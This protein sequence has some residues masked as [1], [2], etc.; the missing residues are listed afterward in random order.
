MDN[1]KGKLSHLEGEDGV[2]NIP[3][4]IHYLAQ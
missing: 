2:E 1:P 4:V 3:E